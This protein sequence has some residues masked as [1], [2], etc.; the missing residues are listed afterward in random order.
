[1]D[2]ISLAESGRLIR[3]INRVVGI[4]ILVITHDVAEVSKF[5]DYACIMASGKVVACGIPDQLGAD[6]NEII[7]QFLQGLPDGPVP[8][9]YPAPDLEKQLL[10]NVARE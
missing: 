7:H 10:D 3:Q 2:H 5:A 6:G 9:H 1:M 8:F 4:T